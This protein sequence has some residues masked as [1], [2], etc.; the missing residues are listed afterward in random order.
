MFHYE[1]LQGGNSLFAHVHFAQRGVNGGVSFFLCGGGGK[2]SPAR[3]EAANSP[4]T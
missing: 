4:A 2:P 3:T 1:G